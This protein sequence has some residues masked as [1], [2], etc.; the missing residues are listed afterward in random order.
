MNLSGLK[1]Q[2][3]RR[4]NFNLYKL[5]INKLDI[6]KENWLR[7]GTELILPE[8]NS[9][10][11]PIILSYYCIIPKHFM[12]I[13]CTNFDLKVRCLISKKDLHHRLRIYTTVCPVNKT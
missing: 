10:F 8:V 12:A 5:H 4:V 1:E 3:P 6:K 13:I 2:Y 11:Y 7:F 9:I